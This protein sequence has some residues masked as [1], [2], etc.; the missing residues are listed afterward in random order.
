[1]HPEIPEGTAQRR[2]SRAGAPGARPRLEL[3]RVCRTRPLE[4][5]GQLVGA[6]EG[7]RKL[8]SHQTDVCHEQVAQSITGIVATTNFR[9]WWCNKKAWRSFCFTFV[10]PS[11]PAG[12]FQLSLPALPL[13]LDPTLALL[14]EHLS[15]FI[16]HPL[17]GVLDRAGIFME[18]GS[19]P[20]QAGQAQPGDEMGLWAGV[21]GMR[22]A[23][24]A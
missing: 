23:T 24:G 9:Y 12:S 19:G 3:H 13:L 2:E 1:M 10:T 8:S 16:P 17:L 21:D 22:W 18:T 5:P 6:A 11:S 20:P 14:P 15:S 7:C 4:P